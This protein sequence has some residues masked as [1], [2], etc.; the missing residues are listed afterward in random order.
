MLGAPPVCGTFNVGQATASANTLFSRVIPPFVSGAGGGPPVLYKVDPT[1][2]YNGGTGMPNWVGDANAF[3]HVTDLWYTSGN[4][5]HSCYLLRPL[6]WTYVESAIGSNT[7]TITVKADPGTWATA[8]IYKYG[9][10]TGGVPNLAN[11]T[12]A[13]ADYVCYQLNDGRWVV[14]VCTTNTSGTT[15]VLTTGTPNV[16]GAGIAKYSPIF[17]MGAVADVDPATG[18]A[19]PLLTSIANT[20]MT[21]S[22]GG[23]GLY[24]SLHR[25]DPLAFVSTNGTAAGVLD[26]LAGF[27]STKF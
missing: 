20:A 26:L 18:I 24:N 14:D 4:T 22:A 27:Y 16:T 7:T 15:L 9:S 2:T 3:S 19:Q 23:M 10:A 12:I 13:S 1:Q 8:G 21:R 5:A 25:G 6:N 17:F 11:N